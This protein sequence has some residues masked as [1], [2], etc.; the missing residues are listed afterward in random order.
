MNEDEISVT[1]MATFVKAATLIDGGW[2][3]SLDIPE[4]QG[5]VVSEIAQLRGY[6]LQVAVVAIQD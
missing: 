3:L 6:R 4:D 5:Q 1:F 2:R